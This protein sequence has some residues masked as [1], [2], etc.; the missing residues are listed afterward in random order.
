M[1]YAD[2]TFRDRNPIK[3]YLQSRRLV[4]ALRGARAIARPDL[5]VC[6]FG[7]GNGEMIKFLA[8]HGMGSRFICYEPSP[9]LLEEAR[10]NIHEIGGVEFF[11]DVTKIAGS[12]V[13]LIYCLE[14]FEHL[15]PRETDEAFK[16]FRR[17]LAPRGRIVIGVP[18]EI[19]FAAL[20]KG[21][22]RIARRYGE[23][24][25]TIANV[26]ASVIGRPPAN[27]PVAEIYPGI[28]F[29]FQHMGFDWRYFRRNLD[30]HFKIEDVY[31]SPFWFG[32]KIAMPEI[33]FVATGRP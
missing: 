6:D 14:V 3:R 1:A 32:G 15:P 22:F 4:S 7:A 2:I 5:S 33:Y 12:S 10:V 13:D 11:G 9:E 30:R 28:A 24:D 17:I 16:Q 21:V 19:W 18:N 29:H 25:A 26:A 20:Y 8:T 23:F 31:T 27:R